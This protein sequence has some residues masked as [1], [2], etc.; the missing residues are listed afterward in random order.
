MALGDWFCIPEKYFGIYYISAGD[1]Q[2]NDESEVCILTIAFN[3]FL[4]EAIISVLL[5]YTYSKPA[6]RGVR[7]RTITYIRI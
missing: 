1:V 3:W 5:N 4:S 2:R 7:S 6:G